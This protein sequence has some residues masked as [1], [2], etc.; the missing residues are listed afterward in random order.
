MMSLLCFLKR[1]SMRRVFIGYIFGV[2]SAISIASATDDPVQT[3]MEAERAFAHLS[4][5]AGT[6]SA[7]L[8]NLAE[9]GIVL[10]PGPV[11]GKLWIRRNPSN[12]TRL[13]W[14][15]TYAEVS[16]AG[17]LGFTTGPWSA[18]SLRDTTRPARYG[19]YVSVW[20]NQKSEGWKLAFDCGTG[21]PSPARDR[22]AR[23][24]GDSTWTRERVFHMSQK[25][26]QERSEELLENDRTLARLCE[27]GQAGQV[28]LSSM[29]LHAIAYR[30]G[31]PPV[32]GR[33]SIGVA[34]ASQ[35]DMVSYLPLAAEVARSGDLGYTYGSITRRRA[36]GYY[37][38]IWRRQVGGGWRVIVDL[39]A[40][41]R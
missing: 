11:N 18:T 23:L 27:K 15:P 13:M 28:L 25:D 21:H 9:D 17:D 5:N 39:E 34:S 32:F 4:V 3:L 30:N 26:L 2:L 12:S 41:D 7:F 14:E 20:R 24:M 6:D 22:L 36:E 35:S 38:R 40:I 10:R 33:D 16:A 29:D 8:A 1:T 31:Q 37:L 19:H